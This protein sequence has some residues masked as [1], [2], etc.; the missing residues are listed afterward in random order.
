VLVGIVL[1]GGA[2][3]HFWVADLFQGA[4]AALEVAGLVLR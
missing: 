4:P 1:L 3:F 2:P